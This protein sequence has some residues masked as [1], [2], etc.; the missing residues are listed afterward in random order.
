[1]TL[2]QENSKSQNVEPWLR[3]KG[4]HEQAKTGSTS[5]NTTSCLSPLLF[6][7]VC[8]N[9][10]WRHQPV[11]SAAYDGYVNPASPRIKRRSYISLTRMCWLWHLY[12]QKGSLCIFLLVIGGQ[13]GESQW[14]YSARKDLFLWLGCLIHFFP[15]NHWLCKLWCKH[16]DKHSRCSVCFVPAR[17]KWREIASWTNFG[18]TLARSQRATTLT[19]AESA[20]FPPKRSKNV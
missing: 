2:W 17:P 11:D 18:W 19:G 1:M 16:A 14:C 20:R 9:G 8:V 6:T 5:P 12:L 15:E 3:A 10:T 7:N 4:R 13:Q